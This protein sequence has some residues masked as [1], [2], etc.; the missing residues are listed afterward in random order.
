MTATAPVIKAFSQG[1][2]VIVIPPRHS[3]RQSVCSGSW[4]ASHSVASFIL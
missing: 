4:R 3:E 1:D 2:F